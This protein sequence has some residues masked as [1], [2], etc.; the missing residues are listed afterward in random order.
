MFLQYRVSSYQAAHPP[1]AVNTAPVTKPDARLAK[2]RAGV[3]EST[4]IAAVRN[5]GDSRVAQ[6]DGHF[7]AE[8]AARA[9]EENNVSIELEGSCAFIAAAI[10]RD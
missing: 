2:S 10:G 6:G 9:G 3:S 5:E 4:R 8:I 1:S 7:T